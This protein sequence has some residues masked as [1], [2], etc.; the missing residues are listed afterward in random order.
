M[1]ISELMVLKSA[2]GFYLGK[3]Q[4]GYPYSRLSHY[5]YSEWEPSILIG[6]VD[7]EKAMLEIQEELPR[8]KALKSTLGK[9]R[10]KFLQTSLISFEAGKIPTVRWDYNA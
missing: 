2:G 4:N 6:K 1:S 7:I 5:Y 3:T 9:R 8:A 10:V